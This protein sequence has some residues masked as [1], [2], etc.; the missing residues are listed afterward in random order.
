MKWEFTRRNFLQT[1]SLTAISVLLAEHGLMRPAWAEENFTVASTGGSWGD[2]VR[3]SFIEGTGFEARQGLEVSYSHQLE[4][5]A[6]SKVLAQ[7]GNPPFSV[8]GH[9]EA[10]AT[11]MADGGCLN[12]YDLSI[13]TNYKNLYPAATLGSRNGMD[14]FWGS[15]I[16]LVFSLTYNNKQASKPAS[17]EDM[18]RDEYKGRIGIPAYGWYGMYWLH[19][20][21]KTLGGDENNISPAMEVAA[22]LVRK[23]DAI[24]IENVDHGMKAFTREEIVIAPFWNGRTFALQEQGVP[25]EMAYVPG[26]IQIGNGAVILKGTQFLDAAQHYVNDSLKG[27]NQVGM[28]KRFRY[29]PSDST[30]KLPAEMAHYAL[31][32]TAADNVVSLD[33]EK[34]NAKRA[35]YLERWNKEVLG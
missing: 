20:L 7:C 15:M 22:K 13:V 3:E 26:T 1:T 16:M 19:A 6:T 25:V 12:G 30:Y 14:A 23:H 4:S 9:G 2:G 33:W 31:P 24:I 35:E 27:E 32:S 17:F 8:S 11:L 29:P 5:V 34:I 10:E 28:T 18:F 21:N